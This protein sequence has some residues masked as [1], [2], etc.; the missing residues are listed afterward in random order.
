MG[1]GAL[2]QLNNCTTINLR[3]YAG[4]QTLGFKSFLFQVNIMSYSELATV[5]AGVPGMAHD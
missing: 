1:Y 4:I 3:T 5:P 2:V